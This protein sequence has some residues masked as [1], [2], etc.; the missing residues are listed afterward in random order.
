[1]QPPARLQLSGLASQPK[2]GEPSFSP[3]NLL[4]ATGVPVPAGGGPIC[5]GTTEAC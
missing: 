5:R 1:M 4:L 2:A 3:S